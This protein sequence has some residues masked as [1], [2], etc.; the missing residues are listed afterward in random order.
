M[1]K[2]IVTEVDLV[3][4]QAKRAAVDAA[5]FAGLELVGE[6]E[7]VPP[8]PAAGAWL[9][10]PAH[11]AATILKWGAFRGSPAT[12]ARVWAD[13][14]RANQLGLFAMAAVTA[15]G[16]DGVLDVA[17]GGPSDWASAATGGWDSTWRTQCRKA[18]SLWGKLRGLHLSMAHEFNNAPSDGSGYAWKVYAKDQ[19]NFRQ[20]WA[21]WARI[22]REEM[23][24]KGSAVKIVL[25][26]NSDTNGG[27]SLAGGLPD[28][29]TF[30]ILGVDPYNFWPSIPD[31]AAWDAT[32]NAMKGDVPRGIRSWV[33]LAEKLGKPLAVPEW[34]LAPAGD[35]PV[36]TPFYVR[37]MHEFFASIAPTDPYNPGPGEL[38]GEAFFNAWPR[39]QIFPGGAN[40]NARAAYLAL[41]WGVAP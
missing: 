28:P 4:L 29:S 12:Y 19:A 26:C 36:D 2:R 23:A 33:K 31:Q 8:V 11:D 9:S 7:P 37:A 24:T 15:T 14:D 41:K 1:T 13:K 40:A 39:G 3:D 6:P 32:K 30:D 20:A 38:A 10:G 16:W 21:R 27:W 5:W 25:S 35:F 22:V 18:L 17:I 34:G